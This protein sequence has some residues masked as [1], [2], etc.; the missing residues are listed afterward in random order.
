MKRLEDDAV[1]TRRRGGAGTVRV[2][3]V[4]PSLADGGGVPRVA[5]FL[6]RVLESSERYEPFLVSLAMSSRDAASLR[7][8]DPSTWLRGIEV[9]EGVWEGRTYRHVG[10]PISEVE[11][12]RYVPRRALDDLLYDADLVQVVAGAPCWAL[13]ALRC[14]APVLLQVATSTERERAPKHR[15]ERGPVGAWRRAMTAVTAR[16]DR[17]ALRRAD[18]VLVE[19]RWMQQR[20]ESVCEP[21]R[22]VFAPPGVDVNRFRPR[23]DGGAP[24]PEPYLLSVAR[25]D[26]PRKRVGLL[27]E[28][29]ARLS[30]RIERAPPLW[31]AGKSGPSDAAWRKARA[32]G[33]AERIRYLGAPSDEE[34]AELYRNALLFALSSDEEGFGLVLVEAMASGVPVVSTACGGPDDIVTQGDEGFLVPVGDAD[35]LAAAMERLIADPGRRATMGQRARRTAVRDYSFEAA[36]AAFLKEYD[37]LSG[38]AGGDGSGGGW[39]RR[40]PVDAGE[41][42]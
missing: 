21:G 17:A 9:R 42:A 39:Q 35:A 22:V 25:L 38:A 13:T 2:A 10:A 37:V 26:D 27:F 3:L 7:L 30:R 18:R 36:G 5:H 34:L 24:T 15:V 28:A 19:N 11:F 1:A 4:V 32:L 29:Y 8:L 40:V 16:L 20:G 12:M 23:A 33:V 31:L 6:C 41:R 14:E